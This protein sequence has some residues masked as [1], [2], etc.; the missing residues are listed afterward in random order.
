[1]RVVT[2]TKFITIQKTTFQHVNAIGEDQKTTAA[3][4]CLES[5]YL[6]R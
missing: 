5:L 2:G 4:W 3:G 6:V 1:M